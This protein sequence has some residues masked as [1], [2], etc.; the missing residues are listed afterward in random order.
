VIQVAEA[1]VA[2]GLL[3]LGWEEFD[4][5]SEVF[6]EHAVEVDASFQSLTALA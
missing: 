5:R 4:G 1:V 3:A 2:D 6:G